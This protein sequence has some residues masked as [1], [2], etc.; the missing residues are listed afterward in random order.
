MLTMRKKATMSRNLR[1]ATR[2]ED[3]ETQHQPM[4][5]SQSSHQYQERYPDQARLPRTHCH[6]GQILYAKDVYKDY[7]AWKRWVAL[8][9]HI[10]L[11]RFLEKLLNLFPPTGKDLHGVYV[12]NAHQGC[13]LTREEADQDAARYPHGYVVPNMPLGQ[14]LTA[15]VPEK[16]SIYFT[17]QDTT[18]SPDH[19]DL[20]PILEEVRQLRATVRAAGRIDF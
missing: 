1:L 16:S 8:Y 17:N 12:W 3:L 14:S 20:T 2:L 15:A 9:F 19:V 18:P 10:P 4:S 5:P 11:F 6:V 7:P 13:F